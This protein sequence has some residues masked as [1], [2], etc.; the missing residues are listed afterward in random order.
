MNSMSYRWLETYKNIKTTAIHSRS[1]SLSINFRNVMSF[2]VQWFII[3]PHQFFK[4]AAISLLVIFPRSYLSKSGVHLI[5]HPEFFSKLMFTIYLNKFTRKLVFSMTLAL[6]FKNSRSG[7]F[8]SK[9]NSMNLQ[10]RSSFAHFSL[11]MLL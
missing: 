2:L 1:R 6:S 10:E 7:W 4:V 3:S 8:I 9:T 5:Y 11:S